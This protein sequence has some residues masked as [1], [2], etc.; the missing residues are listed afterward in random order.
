MR[1]NFFSLSRL[2]FYLVR[3][4]VENKLSFRLLVL[5]YFLNCLGLDESRSYC[6]SP[7]RLLGKGRNSDLTIL[8]VWLVSKLNS[9][10]YNNSR[11]R[12]IFVESF[13]I[14]QF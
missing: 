3:K 1:F 12:V 8:V 11:T 14:I 4:S 6:S 5:M 13:D 7:K 2:T 9:L 10:Q